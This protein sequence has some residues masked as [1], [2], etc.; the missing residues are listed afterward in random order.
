MKVKSLSRVPCP[1]CRDPI[2]C[3]LPGSSV[4]GSFQARVLEWGAIAFSRKYTKGGRKENYSYTSAIEVVTRVFKNHQ[5]QKNR[6]NTVNYKLA[7][8]CQVQI[9]TCQEHVPVTE[10]QQ[11]HLH[12]LLQRLGEGN[13]TPLQY[14]CLENPMDR[15]AW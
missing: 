4:H 10:Q 7:L 6:D 13:G 8:A 5:R 12:L 11:G 3:S 15:G 2:D 9:G 1:T 14:S